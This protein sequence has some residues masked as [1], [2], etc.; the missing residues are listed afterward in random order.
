MAPRWAILNAHEDGKK[1]RWLASFR[2]IINLII[3]EGLR[4][5]ACRDLNR[6]LLDA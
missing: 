2:R 6:L 5:A 3:I 1:Y 4:N